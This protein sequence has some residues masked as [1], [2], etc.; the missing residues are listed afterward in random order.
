MSN[1]D[2]KVAGE[3]KG[4]T[5]PVDSAINKLKESASKELNNKIEAQVKKTLD[6]IRIAESEKAA[7]SDLMQQ[8]EE[9]KVAFAKLI[10]SL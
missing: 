4:K 6:A 2:A 1:D 7:L 3:V 10:K 9:D 8:S 5:N